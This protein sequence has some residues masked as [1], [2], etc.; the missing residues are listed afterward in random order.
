MCEEEW[1]SIEEL[2]EWTDKQNVCYFS[3]DSF[4]YLDDF[5][6]DSCHKGD[7]KREESNYE[8]PQDLNWKSMEEAFCSYND[9]II[10]TNE[11]WDNFC[12]FED[13]WYYE[14]KAFKELWKMPALRWQDE[15][16]C[17]NH[18]NVVC[19]VD[20]VSYVNECWM[21]STGMEKD[22]D[23]EF[24]DGKCVKK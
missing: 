6:A 21:K 5:A 22:P 23:A 12:V 7:N 14:L 8:Y 2:Y 19:W 24:V 9:W 10:I 13:G 20:W 15:P 1:W 4:C 16:F 17:S 3:D 11:Y 18:E